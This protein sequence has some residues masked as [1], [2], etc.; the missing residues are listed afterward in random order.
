M[1][2]VIQPKPVYLNYLNTGTAVAHNQQLF[3]AVESIQK[4]G[5]FKSFSKAQQKTIEHEIRDFKLSGV[6]LSAEK[7]KRF[8]EITKNLSRLSHEFENNVLDATMAFKKH[9]TDENELNGIP[10]HAK[11]AAKNLAEK[12]KKEGWLFTLEAPDYL[13]IM[14]FA[15]NRALRE[16]F[17]RAFVT[18]ASDLAENKKFDNT[19]VMC[20]ILENR[21][22]LATLLGFKDYTEYSL[23]T[24]M[25]DD[26]KTVLQFL[27]ELA[28]KTFPTAKKEFQTLAEFAKTTL[29]LETFDAW[30][31]AFA[32]EK[33][34]QEKYAISQ[35][36]VRPYFPE[37]VVL[38]GLFTIIQK[39]YGVTVK[40]L[41]NT[42]VWHKDARCFCLTDENG[43]PK[44]HLY[45][46]LYARPH[47]RGGAWMDEAAVR[48]RLNEND[49][50]LPAAYVTCN[51]PGPIGDDP[52]L[53]SHD[54][55]VT[56]FHE[57]G[58]ALQHILT[59]IDVA[60]VSGIQG[61]PWDSVELASQ[62]FEN[63]AWENE[64]IQF[65]AQHYQTKEPLPDD[66][67]Q[68]MQDAKNFQS[69]MQMMRQL[70]FS[71]FDFEM[72]MHKGAITAEEIQDILNGVRKK[73]TVVP[74]PDF[75]RFQNGFSHI[76][77]GG[78]AAGYYS[79]K[80]A[81]VMACDAFSLFQEKG[82]FDA[83]TARK[84]K[85]TFLESG[86]AIEPLDLFIEFRGRK[87]EVDALLKQSGIT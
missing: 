69:A 4:N 55:V 26:P 45:M 63:W 85:E 66:L 9:I 5:E 37:P 46:D 44:A 76:F 32:A 15:D 13:A 43:D 80:W 30:D 17:Y 1:H 20:G 40:P 48:R 33:L 61:V 6:H 68:R 74:V 25:V 87:P 16:E 12:E 51:F 36:D 60:S 78:Y 58:H 50:Q 64:S 11:S 57:C 42:D 38:D 79:Y 7:K 49:I 14:M 29:G 73:V 22:E 47:K 23:A 24:K 31:V 71:L 8:A 72:H 41:D 75:N 77:G 84:F 3:H 19:Q 70:E 39:L 2:C 18:R 83:E 10:A 28:E 86:G 65:I 34:R 35:E 54:D 27:N 81:E 82:I 67:L 59:K 56:L 62:F 21:Y 53:F 52:A